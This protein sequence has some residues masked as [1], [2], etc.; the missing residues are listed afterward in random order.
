MAS[1]IRLQEALCFPAAV[2][3]IVFY[4]R[5]PIGQVQ[6]GTLDATNVRDQFFAKESMF[7][8][9]MHVC[10]GCSNCCS[11]ESFVD[12]VVSDCHSCAPDEHRTSSHCSHLGTG[13]RLKQNRFHVF[14]TRIFHLH[15]KHTGSHA[16]SL[17]YPSQ[18][19]TTSLSTPS[20]CTP[21]R[22][23]TRP[24]TRPLLTSSSHGDYTF[25]GFIECVFRSCA[26]IDIGYRN[27]YIIFVC[28][29]YHPVL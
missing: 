17:L 6:S 29:T 1:V 28:T 21:V 27:K 18:M 25:A 10:G 13:L 22:P 14:L 9:A 11:S 3:A 5:D 4:G 8:F 23:S 26:G 12:H 15:T 7:H 19:S 20:T 16:P 24:S 2:F